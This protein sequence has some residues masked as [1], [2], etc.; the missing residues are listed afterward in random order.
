MKIRLTAVF[1][2]LLPSFI[3]AQNIGGIWYGNLMNDS[4]HRKQNF[5]LG[6]SEYNGKITGYTYTT[7]IEN[8]TFYY[9]IKKIKAERK[10][11]YL[12]IEDVEMTGNNFPEKIAKGVRQ[13]TIFPLINDNDIDINNGKWNTNQTKKY[14]SLHGTVELKEL[15]DE[16]ESDLIAHLQEINIKTNIAVK[17]QEKKTESMAEK[18]ITHTQQS[19]RSKIIASN[20]SEPKDD[21]VYSIRQETTNNSKHSAEI[22]A[23]ILLEEK[24]I[25]SEVE[26]NITQKTLSVENKKQDVALNKSVKSSPNNSPAIPLEKNIVVNKPTKGV[27]LKPQKITEQKQNIPQNNIA[28]N[29]VIKKTESP[30]IQKNITSPITNS[31]KLQEKITTEKTTSLPAIVSERKNQTIREVVFKKDSLILSIYDNGIVDGD[32]VSV[33]LNGKTIF[34]KE[35]LKETATKKTVY[36][37]PDMPDSMLLVLF[38]ENLGEIPP[39]TGLLTIRDGEDVYQVRFSADFSTNASVILRRK[40]EL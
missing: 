10:N 8:D 21:L 15:E 39:N 38:A 24:R 1:I 33:F 36:I 17:K 22:G 34:S 37:T 16:K 30:P 20:K 18:N 27:D 19:V 4:T 12:I 11:G 14:Y 32:T 13:T 7:F 23:K 3:L 28:K 6:L 25:N 5:E 31:S 40:K 26:K 2:L 35:R 29:D 9:S